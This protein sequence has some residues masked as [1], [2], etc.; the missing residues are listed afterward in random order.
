M[1]EERTA[2]LVVQKNSKAVVSWQMKFERDAPTGKCFNGN[3]AGLNLRQ[4]ITL[5]KAIIPF[6]IV[7]FALYIFF[8]RQPDYLDG[9]FTTG[10]VHFAADTA[11]KHDVAKASFGVDTAYYLI[12][13]TYPLRDLTEGEKVD[14]IY[15]AANPQQ[16]AVYRWWG[17]WIKWD[18]LVASI[19]I[20]VIFL[21]AANA[22]T[23]NP[24]PESLIEQ[25]QTEKFPNRRKYD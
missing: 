17:Y 12:N 6:Y 20:P 2:L 9:E 5:Y 14:I 23:R 25:M 15:E 19:L 3:P 1:A 4:I 7:C 16:A 13:A 11:S 24:T 10:T 22:I 21:F 8:T 18:E